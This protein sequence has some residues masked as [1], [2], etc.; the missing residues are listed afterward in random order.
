MFP[1]VSRSK[2]GVTSERIS[3]SKTKLANN[4]VRHY[5][6]LFVNVMDL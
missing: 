1:E 5:V 4:L 6:E 2:H 3:K